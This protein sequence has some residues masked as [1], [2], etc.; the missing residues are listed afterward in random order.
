V[1]RGAREREERV[2][3]AGIE[4]PPFDLHPLDGGAAF[5]DLEHESRR[6]PPVLIDAGNLFA[7]SDS[8]DRFRSPSAIEMRASSVRHPPARF[9]TLVDTLESTIAVSSPRMSR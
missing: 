7:D 2:A 9:V 6:E 3:T 1:V 4:P 5:E 8:G